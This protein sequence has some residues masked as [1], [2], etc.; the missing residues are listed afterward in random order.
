LRPQQR[1]GLQSEPWAYPDL[2]AVAVTARLVSGFQ[3]I[4]GD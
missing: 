2:Q 3:R 4:A 1:S